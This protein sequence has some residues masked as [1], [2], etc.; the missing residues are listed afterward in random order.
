MEIK[1]ISDFSRNLAS[2]HGGSSEM[3][4]ISSVY[5]GSSEMTRGEDRAQDKRFNSNPSNSPCSA[6]V[7]V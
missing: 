4:K 3:I 5:G 1:D 6:G 2:V 7:L